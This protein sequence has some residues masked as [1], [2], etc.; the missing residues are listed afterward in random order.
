M[1]HLA[2]YE[3]SMSHMSSVIKKYMILNLVYK[4]QETEETTCNLTFNKIF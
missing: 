1:D 2:L 3:F 4:T